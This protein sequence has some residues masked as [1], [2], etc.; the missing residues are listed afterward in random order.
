M[1]SRRRSWEYR[2]RNT[3]IQRVDSSSS[4]T[5]S[6]P[7]ALRWGVLVTPLARPISNFLVL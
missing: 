6:R 7:A 5:N 4:D 1:N 3:S 2:R